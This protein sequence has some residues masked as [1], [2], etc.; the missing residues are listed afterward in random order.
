MASRLNPYVSFDG[1]AHQAMEFY[2]VSSAGP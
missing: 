2:E 1:N